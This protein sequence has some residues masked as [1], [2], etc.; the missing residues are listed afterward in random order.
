M[1]GIQSLLLEFFT[2]VLKPQDSHH[3]TTESVSRL[4]Q[5]FAQDIIFGLSKGNFLTLKH[6]SVGL[7]LHN[8]TGQKLPLI[9]L[10]HL[11]QS[12]NYH[13]IREIETA[14]AEMSETFMKNGMALPI[15]PKDATSIAPVV[16]W[17][18]NFDKFVDTGT[19]AG[20][21]HNTYSLRGRN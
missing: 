5:S 21:I 7:G 4:A 11:G 6:T 20:S 9:I 2:A 1:E 18:D 14:Q 15:Q 10:S 12:I 13:T 17:Y 16:F 8:M 3:L 19:G